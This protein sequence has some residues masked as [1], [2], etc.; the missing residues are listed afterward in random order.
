MFYDRRRLLIIGGAVLLVLALAG[1]T[2]AI[3]RSRGADEPAVVEEPQP[4]DEP[5]PV[6][7]TRLNTLRL[8]R[9]YLEAGEYQRALDLVDG[10]LISN[11][12]DPDARAIKDEI[13]A[14]KRLADDEAAARAAELAAA[15]AQRERVDPDL[16]AR[17]A[18]AEAR[19][20][21]AEAAARAAEAEAR[22]REAEIAA[23][24]QAEEERRREEQA[25]REA[26]AERA[27]QEELARMN[28]EER[29]KTER[30]NRLLDDGLAALEDERF[31]AARESFDEVLS[32]ELADER[33]EN[34]SHALAYARSA[35]SYFEEDETSA[36]NRQRAIR[37]ANQA[38]A[39]DAEVWEPHFTLGQIYQET[40]LYDESIRSFRSAA[41]LNPDNARIFFE[42][43]NSQF[44]AGMF[45]DARASY[46]TVVKMDPYF[47]NA[48]FNLGVTNLAIDDPARALQA[49]YSGPEIPAYRMRFRCKGPL[50]RTE[51]FLQATGE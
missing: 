12:D 28:E 4:A 8:A 21:E 40:E 20:R 41:R 31:Q 45:R 23:Q 49:W 16:A 19:R 17:Q 24:L 15:A 35:R 1:G 34:R 33:V 36:T 50:Q 10:L 43:G 51:S 11:A 27:R 25:A 39:R 14:A 5:E 30:I 22:A 3:L 44:R 18:E 29:L 13:L 7:T 9:E 38:I 26:E 42:L 6:D 32:I 37:L 47:E 48:Y 2:F 46:E